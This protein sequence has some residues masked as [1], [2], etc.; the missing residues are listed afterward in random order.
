MKINTQPLLP[1]TFYNVYNRGI[2][3]EQ[4]F[5][6]ERNY[7]HFLLQYGKFVPPIA[8]TYAYCLLG[9]HFHLLIRTRAEEEILLFGKDKDVRTLNA[10]RVQNPVSVGK[11]ASELISLQFSNLFNSYHKRSTRLITA[12]VVYLKHLSAALKSSQ[13]VTF[14]NY[15]II[16]TRTHKSTVSVL[17]SGIIHIL[18]TGR[19]LQKVE[20][21]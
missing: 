19:T 18:L 9:N 13:T 4:L 2:N 21:S 15:F 20:R 14:P 7:G 8:D 10:D 6:E 1:E 11:S 16:S 17:I 3:G 12:R 5:K